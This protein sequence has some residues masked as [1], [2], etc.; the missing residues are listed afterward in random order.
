MTAEVLIYNVEA[1]VV[2]ADSAIT[3]GG[4]RVWE[5]GNKVFSLGPSHTL[6]IMYNNNA[7][8]AGIPWETLIKVY[9]KNVR[10]KSFSTVTDLSADFASFVDAMLTN[11]RNPEESSILRFAADAFEGTL[12]TFLEEVEIDGETKLVFDKSEYQNFLSSVEDVEDLESVSKAFQ[13]HKKLIEQFYETFILSTYPNIEFPDYSFHAAIKAAAEK[14]V[15]TDGFTGLLFFGFGEDQIFPEAVSCAIDGANS[16][17]KRHWFRQNANAG[18]PGRSSAGI[19]AFAQKDMTRLFMEGILPSNMELL[20]AMV[21]EY[22]HEDHQKEFLEN[23]EMVIREDVTDPV[24]DSIESL[25]KE[26]LAITAESLVE[27]TSLRRKI[28]S[29]VR[30]VAGP[31]DVAIV[32]KGDGFVWWKR[33]HYFDANLN[34]DFFVRRDASGADDED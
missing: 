13:R 16:S 31:V 29:D 19:V 5:H 32:S 15:I 17:W 1:M 27:L 34:P 22:V 12:G 28:D 26:E 4:K 30:S 14:R 11:A 9:K 23:F 20:E 2:A 10:S 18:D 24:L 25:P 33:K 8:V 21:S 7:E 3:V 6:G